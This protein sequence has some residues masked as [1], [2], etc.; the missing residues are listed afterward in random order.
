[1]LEGRQVMGKSVT[2]VDIY[3]WILTNLCGW[4][5]SITREQFEEV[6]KVLITVLVQP[7]YSPLACILAA[8]IWCFLA[9]YGT[10]SICLNHLL[11]L[12]SLVRELKKGPF[13]YSVMI[14]HQLMNRLTNFLNSTDLGS[15]NER[16]ENQYDIIALSSLSC[17][18]AVLC[19]SHCQADQFT[20]V[21]SIWQKLAKGAYMTGDSLISSQLISAL[22][23][24]TLASIDKAT[25][26]DL[27]NLLD[28]I[29]QI[30]R[31]GQ[32]KRYMIMCM[33]NMI[34]VCAVNCGVEVRDKLAKLLKSFL[35]HLS[36]GNG[37]SCA[38]VLVELASR[39]ISLELGNIVNKWNSSL[40]SCDEE[41]ESISKNCWSLESSL[42][43]V[44]KVNCTPNDEMDSEPLIRKVSPSQSRDLSISKKRKYSP[45]KL[46]S[47]N[48][49]VRFEESVSDL[50]NYVI[51]EAIDTYRERI[52]KTVERLRN[53]LN[54]KK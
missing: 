49:I 20:S 30:A 50:E 28:F 17:E 6:E 2:E 19:L 51:R 26:R 4:I 39:E 13:S 22:C 16:Q 40:I 35:E 3:C 21:L 34:R 25:T 32:Y 29:D 23:E 47:E 43:F 5:S 38:G 7:I 44:K 45:T 31:C 14:I 9:R 53:H 48:V 11:F 37:D 15:W 12:S 41:F 27:K 1:M 10:S 54:E 52:L 46:S 42:T 33:L 24:A 8:D 36:Y 18:Q